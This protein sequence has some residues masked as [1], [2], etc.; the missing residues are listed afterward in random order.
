MTDRR[1]KDRL[2]LARPEV[3]ERR[4]VQQR[5]YRAQHGLVS[6]LLG[7]ARRRA[8]LYGIEFSLTHEDIVVPKKCPVLGIAL[9]SVEGTRANRDSSPS[10][11]RRDNSRGYVKG[12]VHV[13][14]WRA[15]NLKSDGTV[16]E[17]SA[18]VNYMRGI[19]Q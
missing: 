5:A 9:S 8:K 15:N 12:N 13:I 19:R 11:D 1:D 14:S 16:K 3:Q 2:Y 10:L 4:R 17:L 6:T 18:V 7:R